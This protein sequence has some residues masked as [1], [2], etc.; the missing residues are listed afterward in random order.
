MMD[1]RP[2]TD[3]YAVS[4]QIAPEDIAA[5]A[6]AGFQ[7]VIC[8]RPDGENPADLHLAA[9]RPA[10]EAAGLSVVENP[11]AGGGLTMEHIDTQRAAIDN[12]GKVLA[13]CASGN[14]SSILY[15]LAMAGRAPTDE[16]IQMG[17]RYGYQVPQFRDLIE[18]LAGSG[19]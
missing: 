12:G 5:I 17:A 15:A 14:R 6:A 13:Y 11:M 4:P 10:L 19:A 8:N 16:L 1:I 2:L 18:K 7:T 9:L 3:S